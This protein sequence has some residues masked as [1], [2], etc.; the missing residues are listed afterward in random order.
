MHLIVFP[1]TGFSILRSLCFWWYSHFPSLG[2]LNFRCLP[3]LPINWTAKL[4]GAVWPGFSLW[5]L[6]WRLSRFPVRA[7]LSEPFWYKPPPWDD[8]WDRPLAWRA[9]RWRLR[10]RSCRFLFFQA[11]LQTSLFLEP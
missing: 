6:R 2:H 3:P 5:R 8:C 4:T 7:P 1:P 9:L 10:D 11:F